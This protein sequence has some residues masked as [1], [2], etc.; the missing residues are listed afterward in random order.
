MR[1]NLP[2]SLQRLWFEMKVYLKTSKNDKVGKLEM[3][4]ETVREGDK[5]SFGQS[6][7]LG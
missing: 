3:K 1:R 4:H 5:S 6:D 2:M 7:A